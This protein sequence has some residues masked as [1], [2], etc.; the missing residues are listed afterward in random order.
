M[1]E[2]HIINILKLN[3][4]KASLNLEEGLLKDH[5]ALIWADIFGNDI[6]PDYLEI[7]LPDLAFTLLLSIDN[8]NSNLQINWK[9]ER[10]DTGKSWKGDTIPF[11]TLN[12]SEI[13]DLNFQLIQFT[14][15]R[16]NEPGIKTSGPITVRRRK[17]ILL[18]GLINLGDAATYL[19]VPQHWLKH[20][21]P[22]TTWKKTVPEADQSDLDYFWDPELIKLLKKLQNRDFKHDQEDQFVKFISDKCCEGDKKWAKEIFKEVLKQRQHR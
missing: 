9:C 15:K 19:G 13:N 7:V 20:W 2:A 14:S 5:L 21:I 17:K 11:S 10:R 18:E 8:R 3:G 22:C 16:E 6:D 4:N 1:S 12:E